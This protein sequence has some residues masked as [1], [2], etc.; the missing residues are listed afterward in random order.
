MD[1]FEYMFQNKKFT[2]ISIV[3]ILIAIGASFYFAQFSDERDDYFRYEENDKEL[4]Y[5]IETAQ[6]TLNHFENA[7][8]SNDSNLGYF[9]LKVH[10]ESTF[11]DIEYIR[12][13]DVYLQDN[14][15]YGNVYSEPLYI[16]KIKFDDHLKINKNNIVDWLYYDYKKE[17]YYGGYTTMIMKKRLSKKKQKELGLDEMIFADDNPQI[18]Y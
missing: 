15:F 14:E 3:V 18:V 16:D 1:D 7:L 4:D 2:L 13:I 5:A 11:G 10:Y 12:F 8:L 17:V 9:C 6:F